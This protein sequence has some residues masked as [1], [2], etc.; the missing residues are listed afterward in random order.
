MKLSYF[1]LPGATV[2]SG[3][4]RV[5]GPSP[6]SFTSESPIYHYMRSAFLLLSNHVSCPLFNIPTFTRLEKMLCQMAFHHD[7]R[8]RKATIAIH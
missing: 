3:L 6:W 1:S 7:R 8:D 2:D 5:P 4:P